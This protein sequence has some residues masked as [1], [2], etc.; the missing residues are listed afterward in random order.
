MVGVVVRGEHTDTPHAVGLERIDDP[1]DVVGGVDQHRLAA[2]TIAD[3]V[4]EV[5]HLL[6]HLVVGGEVAARKQLAE[7][8]AIAHPANLDRKRKKADSRVRYASS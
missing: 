7:V 5:D 6:S 3:R 1:V 8:E 2:L 4:D